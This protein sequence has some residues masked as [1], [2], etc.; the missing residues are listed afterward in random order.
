MVE[1]GGLEKKLEEKLDVDVSKEEIQKYKLHN[2]RNLEDV[3]RNH[4]PTP[5]LKKV[6]DYAVGFGTMAFS[7][8]VAGPIGPAAALM[9]LAGEYLNA[10]IRKRDFPSRQFRNTALLWSLISI[11]GSMLYNWMNATINV[12]TTIGM[13]QRAAVEIPAVHLIGGP[14]YHLVSYP[15]ENR[16][17]KGLLNLDL[18]RIWWKNF[19]ASMKY[20]IVPE[21]LMAR[22]APAY[23]HFPA[24]LLSKMFYT[25]TFGSRRVRLIDPYILEHKKIRGKSIYDWG[26]QYGI[27]PGEGRGKPVYV[28]DPEAYKKPKQNYTP[29]TQ[30]AH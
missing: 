19:K 10:K 5:F 18:K 29:Q 12:K 11:P 15:L 17:F 27:I 4:K 1:Q 23:I 9:G 21:M 7:F 30:P 26:K 2:E 22:F 8:F 6:F 28:P 13:L 14:A 16:K 3:I 25:I 20:F 24:L